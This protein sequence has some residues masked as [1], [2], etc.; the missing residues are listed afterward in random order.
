MVTQEVRRPQRLPNNWEVP[1]ELRS[2]FGSKTG[3]QR[4]HE[5]K[6]HVVI[7]LH[8]PPQARTARRNAIYFWRH[9]L[10]EWSCS[11]G[12][13]GVETLPDHVRKYEDAVESL[14]K[15][16]ASAQSTEDWFAILAVAAPLRRA[17]CNMSD[18]FHSAQQ[19][20]PE[21]AAAELQ[22]AADAA[23][24]VARDVELLQEQAQHSIDFLLA[25]QNE[26]QALASEAHVDAAHR[27]NIIAALF[28]PLATIASVFGMNVPS[29]ME[30]ASLFIFWLIVMLGVGLG[31]AVV[32]S[33]MRLKS[34]KPE[35]W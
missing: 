1:Q 6:G 25:R 34:W 14:E 29:G 7:L 12:R 8:H 10:G 33:V 13:H 11:E 16:V 18:A 4:A 22:E 20:M 27:L 24:E 19:L 3:R 31:V 28:L 30:R 9:S 26:I 5:F 17:A 15:R 21:G 2:R 23:H 35:E 32:T